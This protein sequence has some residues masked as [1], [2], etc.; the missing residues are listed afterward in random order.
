MLIL[1]SPPKTQFEIAKCNNYNYSNADLS[2]PHTFPGTH[3]HVWMQTTLS[4][5][6]QSLYSSWVTLT[7]S[8]MKAE[9]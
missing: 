3:E 9:N 8:D 2:K 7:L 4:T 6:L 1:F 5:H